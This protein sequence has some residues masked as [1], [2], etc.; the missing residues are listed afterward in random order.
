MCSSN[1]TPLFYFAS[2]QSRHFHL[3]IFKHPLLHTVCDNRPTNSILD[4]LHPSA[5]RNIRIAAT[6]NAMLIM[7]WS[8]LRS[9]PLFVRIDRIKQNIILE[10]NDSMWRRLLCLESTS[11][12]RAATAIHRFKLFLDFLKIKKNESG[13]HSI[14][15]AMHSCGSHEH[16]IK[17]KKHISA[18]S[19]CL[20][21]DLQGAHEY[22]RN[23]YL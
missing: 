12:F 9:N 14:T 3:I 5:T 23:V 2:T 4:F 16:H 19:L 6:P 21:S 22:S 17:H 20:A 13:N 8:P 10:N 18:A 7:Q 15:R 1:T 11:Y